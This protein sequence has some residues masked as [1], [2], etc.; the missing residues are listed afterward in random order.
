[1]NQKVTDCHFVSTEGMVLLKELRADPN[2]VV[3][4]AYQGELANMSYWDSE[5]HWPTVVGFNGSVTVT[6]PWAGLYYV[7]A[8]VYDQEEKRHLPH[9]TAVLDCPPGVTSYEM[10][11]DGDAIGQFE[12]HETDNRERLFFLDRLVKFK[13]GEKIS[14]HTGSVGVHLVQDILLMASRP[15]I[16]SRFFDISHVE[17][18]SVEVDG[19]L[20][21]RLTWVTSCPRDKLIRE[22]GTYPHPVQ[23][24]LFSHLRTGKAH[25]LDIA[26]RVM[27]HSHSDFD[28]FGVLSLRTKA[29]Y[30]LEQAVKGNGETTS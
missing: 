26:Q 24:L 18:E 21:A 7:G 27:K 20:K 2:N 23:M 10:H 29:C 5:S 19:Q 30:H 11:I 4:H 14:L 6:V 16:R 17:A 28:N 3:L 8:V 25:N 13:G 9:I 22:I 1:M 12:P 15:P